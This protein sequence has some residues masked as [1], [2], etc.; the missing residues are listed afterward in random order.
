MMDKV[1]VIIRVIGRVQGVG[2]RYSTQ[3]IAT[4]LSLCGFVTNE[5]DGSVYIEAEGT[6]EQINLLIEW[7]RRGSSRAIV[8]E[9]RYFTGTLMNYTSFRVK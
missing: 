9:V 7:C 2:F 5:S 3:Q 1:N 4:S 6:T 8:R